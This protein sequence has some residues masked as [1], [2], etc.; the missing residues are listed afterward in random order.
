MTTFKYDDP[1][2]YPYWNGLSPHEQWAVIPKERRDYL[3][4]VAQYHVELQAKKM[5]Q[6][7]IDN[8]EYAKAQKDLN[9]MKKIVSMIESF[10]KTISETVPTPG[11]N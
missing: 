1:N 3:Y 4:K 9:D 10:E 11:I 2:D 7:S 6:I 5:S 8:V